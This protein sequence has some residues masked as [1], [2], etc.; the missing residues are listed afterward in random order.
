MGA[1]SSASLASKRAATRAQILDAAVATIR[2]EGVAGVRIDDVAATAGVSPGLIY[3]H[4]AN[5]QALVRAGLAEALDRYAAE[6]GPAGRR[7][8][9]AH[10]VDELQRRI[11]LPDD[12]GAAR[13]LV[14]S[15]A[16]EAAVFDPD[17]LPAV[18]QSTGR[19]MAGVADL[20]DLVDLA[21]GGGG[22]PVERARVAEV[23]TALADGLRQRVLSG[24]LQPAEARQLVAAM[25]PVVLAGAAGG[26]G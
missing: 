24:T 22:D 12:D 18:Q 9:L 21:R 8:P 11:G 19:W 13:G 16:L 23:L 6:A 20:V 1:M 4:F 5:R 15:A 14:R 10:L 2:A 26:R 17:L 7:D 3:Y 25:V